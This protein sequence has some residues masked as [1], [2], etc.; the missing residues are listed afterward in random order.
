MKNPF[1]LLLLIPFLLVLPA[2]AD[3]TYRAK[4]SGIECNGCK[5]TIAQSLGK[6]EGVKTIRI[7]KSGKETHTLTVVASDGSNISRTDANKALG[8]AEHYKLRSWSKVR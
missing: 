8:K 6:I 7:R 3:D 2:V 1:F 5:K 4:L